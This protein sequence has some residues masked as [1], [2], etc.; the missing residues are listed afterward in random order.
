LNIGG[1]FFLVNQLDY[2]RG[3]RALMN[4]FHVAEEIDCAKA[5]QLYKRIGNAENLQKA[6]VV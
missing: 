4:C 5:G 2:G 1:K 6:S 3:V